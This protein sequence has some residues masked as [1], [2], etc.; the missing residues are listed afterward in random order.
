MLLFFL[1]LAGDKLARGEKVGQEFTFTLKDYCEATGLKQG[2]S[3]SRKIGEALER[4]KETN[5]KTNIEAGGKTYVEGFS[6]IEKYWY[7]KGPDKLEAGRKRNGRVNSISVRFCDFLWRAIVIDHSL[8]SYNREF[9][10]LSPIKRRLYEIARVHLN[11]RPAF[12]IGLES[13]RDRVGTAQEL[14]NFKDEL[15]KMLVG[16]EAPL[17]GY[18]F[19]IDTCQPSS[20]RPRLGKVVVE[21]WRHSCD[22][23]A[24]AEVPMMDQAYLSDMRQA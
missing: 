17:P 10:G 18:R 24:L 20:K 5:I 16:E 22:I 9:F 11:D 14:K 6:W 19:R 1:G 2:G 4:L 7:D 3:V 21:F 23:D 8:L 15:A 12:R 13:L